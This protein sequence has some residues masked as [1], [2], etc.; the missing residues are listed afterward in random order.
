M[1]DIGAIV[2]IITGLISIFTFVTGASSLQLLKAESRAAEGG[3][4]ARPPP[5]PRLYVRSRLLVWLMFA[6][7][8]ASLAVTLSM[9]LSGGDVE[10][11]VFVLLLIGGVGAAAYVLRFRQTISP[12]VFGVVSTLV[13]GGIGF[14]LGSMSRG[15]E[16]VDAIAGL[17]IGLCITVIAWL[18]RSGDI[19]VGEVAP[20]MMGAARDDPAQL[21]PQTATVDSDHEK[22]VLRLAA[23]HAGEVTITNVTLQTD[24][25]L[26]DA[27]TLLESLHERGFCERMQTETGATIYRFPDLV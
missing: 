26:D 16:L 9:G 25:S 4:Q 19:P 10:G 3:K 17:V 12:L 13:L 2:G 24:L 20:A 11:A 18:F 14:A 5:R 7:F 22:T 6:I 21:Q 15:E 23:E 8:V 1:G 27:R